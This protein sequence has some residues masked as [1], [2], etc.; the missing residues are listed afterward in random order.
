MNQRDVGPSIEVQY[1]IVARCQHTAAHECDEH[2]QR[3]R[4]RQIDIAVVV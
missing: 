2:G 4:Q 1:S 3:E